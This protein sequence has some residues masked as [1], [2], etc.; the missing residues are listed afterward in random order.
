MVSLL[1]VARASRP[2]SKDTGEAPCHV[3]LVKSLGDADLKSPTLFW[4]AA[5]RNRSRQHTHVGIHFISK[6][7][8]RHRI[9]WGRSFSQIG[10]RIGQISVMNRRVGANAFDALERG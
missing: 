7:L 10:E 6:R 5:H 4:I 1:S 8:P 3:R 9:E 2:W